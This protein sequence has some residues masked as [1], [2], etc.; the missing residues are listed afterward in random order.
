MAPVKGEM[1]SSTPLPLEVEEITPEWF[2]SVLDLPVTSADIVKAIHGT[3]SK[4]LFE[5]K[6]SD[7]APSDA[8]SRVC[9][10]GGFNAQLRLLGLVT[11]YRREAEFYYH[12]A[13]SLDLRLPKCWYAGTTKDQG[14]IVVSNIHVRTAR[15]T[16]LTSYLNV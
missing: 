15:K 13:P 14:L 10:K 11:A 16:S 5:L 1:D 2:A 9:V 12:L 7:Q 6:Y 3:A 4:I 8:P